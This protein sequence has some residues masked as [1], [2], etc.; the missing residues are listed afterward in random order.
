MT[1]AD[2]AEGRRQRRAGGMDLELRQS[3]AGRQ[4]GK[5]AREGP[6][7]SAENHTA[8]S[9]Y[10][11]AQAAKVFI[12]GERRHVIKESRDYDKRDGVAKR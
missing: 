9:D 12:E 10:R 7:G 8:L 6:G 4:A 2:V 11:K 5:P 3:G 1:A